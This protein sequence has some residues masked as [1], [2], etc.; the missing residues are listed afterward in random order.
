METTMRTKWAMPAIALL[1]G[2]L[3]LTAAAIGGQPIVGL[4]MLAV[5]VIYGLVLGVFGG[6]NEIVGVLRGQPEDERL[7]GFDLVATAVA[8]LAAILVALGGF[9]WQIAHGQGGTDFALVAAGAGVA[10]LAALLWLRWRH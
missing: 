6:R 2:A 7:A 1:L 8:G 9:L 4:A 3:F 5:M 10:Y